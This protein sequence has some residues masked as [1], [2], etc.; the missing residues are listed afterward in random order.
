MGRGFSTAVLL[1]ALESLP[2]G[3]TE[4]MVHPGYQ[5]SELSRLTSYSAGRACELAALI[6]PEVRATVERIGVRLVQWQDVAW[7][8]G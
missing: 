1:R 3:F 5:D 6:S 2:G 7:G 8:E 4:L